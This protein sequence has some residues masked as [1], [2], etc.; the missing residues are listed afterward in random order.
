M[1][2]EVEAINDALAQKLGL[3]TDLYWTQHRNDDD[4]WTKRPEP[5][6]LIDA[7]G[8]LLLEKTLLARDL[9]IQ[10]WVQAD[11]GTIGCRIYDT[12]DGIGVDFGPDLAVALVL[13]AHKLLKE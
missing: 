11:D 10:Y 9:D 7:E 13:A 2:P 6:S 4:T 8:H 3:W 12:E 5:R 1:T